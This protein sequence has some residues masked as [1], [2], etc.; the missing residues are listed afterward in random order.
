DRQLDRVVGPGDALGALHRLGELLHPAPELLR[1]TE[2]AAE[3]ILR[4]HA[5]DSRRRLTGAYGAPAALSG[6]D[7]CGHR[8]LGRD[9]RRV[10]PR[11]VPPGLRS[12]PRGAP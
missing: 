1:V 9:R 7:L 2:Q 8:R 10:R 6:L 5:I 3:W 4:G 11:T 12:D